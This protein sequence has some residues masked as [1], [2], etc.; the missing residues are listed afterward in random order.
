MTNLKEINFGINQYCGPAVLSALTGEST[1][2]CA[3]VISAVSGKKEIK[4]VERA[5]LKEALRRLRFDVEETIFGGQTLYG[6]LFRM[7]SYDGLYVVFVPH[8]VIAIEVK[9]T[10]IF[11]CY[12]HCKSPLDIKQS[13]RLTQKV[14]L[15]LKVTPKSPPIFIESSI[16]L[17][18]GNAGANFKID[19]YSV[20]KYKNPEDDNQYL[21]GTIRYK[22][23][24][25]LTQILEAFK[26]RRFN[27]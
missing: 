20:N 14:E 6:T 12:N 8:H 24:E 9:D 26:L 25:E 1:D 5:H 11:I 21:L 23:D 13:S 19:I 16:R 3:A 2:R 22:D 18:K 10:E 27:E 17:D 15:V 7:Y 4:A